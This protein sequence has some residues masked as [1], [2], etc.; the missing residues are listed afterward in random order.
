MRVGRESDVATTCWSPS[1]SEMEGVGGPRTSCTSESDPWKEA[2]GSFLRSGRPVA[3]AG[4]LARSEE[5]RNVATRCAKRRRRVDETHAFRIEIATRRGPR[6]R[7]GPCVAPRSIHD[8]L[9]RLSS[10]RRDAEARN[11]RARVARRRR[12]GPEGGASDPGGCNCTPVSSRSSLVPGRCPS[13]RTPVSGGVQ[14][15]R[16]AST[17]GSPSL[18]IALFFRVLD[19]E[20]SLWDRNRPDFYRVRVPVEKETDPNPTEASSRTFSNRI[21]VRITPRQLRRRTPP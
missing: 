2:D 4:V 7:A 3:C 17:N 8:L 14:L 1:A 13:L 21:R 10:P 9:M 16:S 12:H 20:T 5:A 18:W 6:G 19:R 11:A 15:G